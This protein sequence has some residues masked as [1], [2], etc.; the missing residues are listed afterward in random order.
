MAL[1]CSRSVCYTWTGG[2]GARWPDRDATPVVARAMA[3]SARRESLVDTPFATVTRCGQ[4]VTLFEQRDATTRRSFLTIAGAGL[5]G[6][7][8]SASVA[9]AVDPTPAERANMKLVTEFC[10][11]FS[12]DDVDRIMSS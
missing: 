6:M 2:K 10:E 7:V 1:G 5:A 9:A 4:E 12:A 11:A 8:Q 3:L